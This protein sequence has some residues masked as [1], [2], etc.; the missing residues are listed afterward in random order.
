MNAQGCS[1]LRIGDGRMR[2][3]GESRAPDGLYEHADVTT[4]VA[5]EAFSRPCRCYSRCF[6]EIAENG[7]IDPHFASTLAL[8]NGSRRQLRRS[9]RSR[10]S[11][12]LR[13]QA[14]DRSQGAE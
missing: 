6:V 4:S 3:F 2:K 9:A 11:L 5:S 12:R 13:S 8:W 10:E 7:P 14:A 1:R